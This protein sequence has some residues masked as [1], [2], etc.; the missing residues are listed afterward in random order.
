MTSFLNKGLQHLLVLYTEAC[1]AVKVLEARLKK[2]EITISDQG[3]IAEAKSQH[4]EDK[5]KKVTQDAKIKLVAAQ[6]DHDQAMTSFWDGLK[7]S[8]IV[9]LLQ[10]RI[11]MAYEAKDAVFECP[12]WPVDS[13]VAKLKDPRREPC[14]TSF[15]VQ[16]L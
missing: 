6:V 8:V 1:E 4:Y 15:K 7:N 2:A 11:K 16:D 13:L 12:T 3:K 14:A 5:P 9:S 10:A